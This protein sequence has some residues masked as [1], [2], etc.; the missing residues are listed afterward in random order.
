MLYKDLLR[1]FLEYVWRLL[2]YAVCV[3]LVTF[4]GSLLGNLLWIAIQQAC[5]H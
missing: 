5:S 4:L 2:I 3:F 1:F